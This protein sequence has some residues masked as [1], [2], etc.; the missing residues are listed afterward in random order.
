MTDYPEW[1]LEDD[2]N[3]YGQ[4]IVR[5]EHFEGNHYAAIVPASAGSPPVCSCGW[6]RF[7]VPVNGWVELADHLREMNA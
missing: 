7:H 5:A 2:R 3:H 4:P 6:T 1:A